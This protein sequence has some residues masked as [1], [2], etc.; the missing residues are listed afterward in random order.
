MTTPA[1]LQALIEYAAREAANLVDA[2]EV[3]G[4]DP[5]GDPTAELEGDPGFYDRLWATF[6]NLDPLEVVAAGATH[7][8][9][10][11]LLE[12]ARRRRR[13]MAQCA[14]EGNEIP[15]TWRLVE[16]SRE[17]RARVA[18]AP[19]LSWDPPPPRPAPR[20]LAEAVGD[21]VKLAE[22]FEALEAPAEAL[23]S[24]RLV[25]GV[26]EASVAWWRESTGE[27]P[28]PRCE[29]GSLCSLCSNPNAPVRP[30]RSA[31]P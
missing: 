29:C 9:A 4:A 10:V 8:A 21:L 7:R 2:C 23:D 6:G 19:P 14:T 12:A 13:A 15:L 22:S 31:K 5:A 11:E 27:D 26:I 16:G 3:T 20:R 28:R 30:G 25:K 17:L 18:E 24:W 1:R